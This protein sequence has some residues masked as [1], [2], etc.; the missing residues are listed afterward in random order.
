MHL[1]KEL[2]CPTPGRC[3]AKIV[4]RRALGYESFTPAQPLSRLRAGD[5][6]GGHV[7]TVSELAAAVIVETLKWRHQGSPGHLILNVSLGWDGEL[8]NGR[9]FKDSLT[10]AG[11]TWCPIDGYFD[12]LTT[13]G[14]LLD[15]AAGR[16]AGFVTVGEPVTPR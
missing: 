1:A 9:S 6:A 12:G 10:A 3:A 11:A 13:R 4:S 2:A 5:R 7:G 8:C 14:V 15:V 16:K